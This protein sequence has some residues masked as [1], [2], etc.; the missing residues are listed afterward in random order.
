MIGKMVYENGSLKVALNNMMIGDII[1]RDIGLEIAR[2]CNEFPDLEK[3]AGGT[4][5]A[6]V[7][8]QFASAYVAGELAAQDGR[9][10]ADGGNGVGRYSKPADI[11]PDAAEAADALLLLWKVRFNP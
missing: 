1:N 6:L 9:N 2:R 5:E 4:S 10:D 3:K 7:W 8:A 11:A